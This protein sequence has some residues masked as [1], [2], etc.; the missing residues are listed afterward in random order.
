MYYGFRCYNQD[1]EAMGWLYTYDNGRQLVDTDKHFTWCKRWKTQK[2]AEKHFDN[3]NNRWRFQ[4]NGGYLKIEI[5]PEFEEPESAE[6]R[7]QK[8]LEEWSPDAQVDTQKATKNFKFELVEELP[9]EHGFYLF[10]L[11]NGS[12]KEGYFGS[13]PYPHHKDSIRVADCE[14]QYFYYYNCV[15]WL[16]KVE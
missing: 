5:M 7:K 16:K 13:F 15:G 2:G 14:N 1:D 10:L 9:D 8:L 12:I 4:S 11:E 6:E 3:Y